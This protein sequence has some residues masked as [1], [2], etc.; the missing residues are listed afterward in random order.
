MASKHVGQRVARQQ[1]FKR[2]QFG[3]FDARI[4]GLQHCN[5]HRYWNDLAVGS[6]VYLE[7]DPTNAH[8]S[9]AIGVYVWDGAEYQRVGFVEKAVA[10][11]LARE[12]DKGFEVEA[13]VTRRNDAADYYNQVGASIALYA[14]L[15]AQE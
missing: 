1:K 8:D 4:V 13:M 12:L 5:G 10:M 7:R 14:Y 9:N 15:P 6:T 3:R 11:N 2:I